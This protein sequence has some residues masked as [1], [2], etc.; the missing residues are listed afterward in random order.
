MTGFRLVKGLYTVE[1]Q[2]LEL[3]PFNI[4]SILAYHCCTTAAAAAA[5]ARFDRLSA[6]TT[7]TL[8]GY[9]IGCAFDSRGHDCHSHFCCEI[10]TTTSPASSQLLDLALGPM[11]TLGSCSGRLALPLGCPR[12]WDVD[13][14]H[15][16]M[17]AQQSVF[18]LCC[19]LFVFEAGMV[20]A[21]GGFH[22]IDVP[23]RVANWGWGSFFGTTQYEPQ[24][25]ESMLQLFRSG[26]G[27]P[28]IA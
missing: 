23:L 18:H 22:C 6:V 1:D 17:S 16:M 3:L 5:V 13:T 25:I 26:A 21:S 24:R 28:V 14:A 20:G 12:T 4:T 10:A 8:A 11:Q 9:T 27:R 2:L 15:Y 19:A 7:A